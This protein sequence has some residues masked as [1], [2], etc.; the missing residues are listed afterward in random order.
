MRIISGI[1]KGRN[2]PGKVPPNVRPTQDAMRETIFNIISN[3]IDFEGL[4]VCDLCC[5][6]GAMAIEALSRGAEFAYFV[7]IS[8]Q[9]LDF[10]KNVLDTFK[11]ERPKYQI[12]LYRAEKF[13]L[14]DKVNRNIDLIF[15]DPPYKNNVINDIVASISSSRFVPDGAIISIE[16]GIANSL[17]IPENL[18]I[19]A[20]RQY[21]ISKVTLMRKASASSPA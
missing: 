12:S 4:V 3:F 7:D 10:V 6:T 19:I 15:V 20:E 14:S 11:I 5:G 18:E 16:Y 13:L 8:R 1:Y 17:L 9:S 2:I 21:S